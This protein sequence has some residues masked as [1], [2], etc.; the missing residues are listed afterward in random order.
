MHAFPAINSSCLGPHL[1]CKQ[2]HVVVCAIQ[3]NMHVVYIC[4]VLPFV[5]SPALSPQYIDAIQ[6]VVHNAHTHPQENSLGL[7]ANCFC[8][9]LTPFFCVVPPCLHLPV[10]K[11][12]VVLNL[13]FGVDCSVSSFCVLHC[14]LSLSCH[15]LSNGPANALIAVS[16]FLS[17]VHL[18]LA[19]PP[20]LHVA[21]TILV[22]CCTAMA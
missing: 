20:L 3:H 12:I 1:Q 4:F 8:T 5:V 13:S 15:H 17:L 14:H 19:A 7:I 6:F 16:P 21:G 22:N 9:Q 2:V 10:A 11:L 18:L